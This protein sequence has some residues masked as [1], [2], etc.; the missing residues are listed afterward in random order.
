M[1]TANIVKFVGLGYERIGEL[2]C[3][4]FVLTEDPGGG[5]LADRLAARITGCDGCTADPLSTAAQ[6]RIAAGIGAG[7]ADGLHARGL[8]HGVL[9]PSTV[10][11]TG[12][13]VAK[14]ADLGLAM[15]PTMSR[16]LRLA[17]SADPKYLA[18]ELLASSHS[19]GPRW[20]LAADVYALGQIVVAMS[21]NDGKEPA[22]NEPDDSGFVEQLNVSVSS[23]SSDVKTVLPSVSTPGGSHFG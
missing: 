7:L 18:P 9:S 11:L 3:P 2:C 15:V 17:T 8:L 4:R 16:K 19:Q 5:T 20:S 23:A 1:P 22:D 12:A 14:I 6:L 13:G 21:A 10:V